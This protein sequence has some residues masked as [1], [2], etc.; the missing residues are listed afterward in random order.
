VTDR[1]EGGAVKGS[2]RGVM[3]NRDGN[4]RK[5]RDDMNGWEIAGVVVGAIVLIGVLTNAKDLL[6]Y[7]KISSM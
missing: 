7:L 4:T 2:K 6:R 1:R 5:R 3:S